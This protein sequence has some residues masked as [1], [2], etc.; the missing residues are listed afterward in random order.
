MSN[1]KKRLRQEVHFPSFY[2]LVS[3]IVSTSA[4]ESV[5]KY[6]KLLESLEKNDKKKLQL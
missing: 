4:E 5:D 1:N 6:S 2:N 3:I